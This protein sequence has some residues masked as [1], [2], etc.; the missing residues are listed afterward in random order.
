LADEIDIEDMGQGGISGQTMMRHIELIREI[1]KA[2]DAPVDLMG[3]HTCADAKADPKTR[4]FQTLVALMLSSQTKDQV[5]SAAME[6]LKKAG[7][8]IAKLEEIPENELAELLKPVGFYK[9]NIILQI[10]LGM[11]HF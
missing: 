9:V 8:N 2:A 10:K 3:C 7:C 5:T 1:R 6:R 4:R 11:A